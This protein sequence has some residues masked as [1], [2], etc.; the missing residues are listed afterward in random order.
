[1]YA[2]LLRLGGLLAFL[3]L[4]PAWAISLPSG[5]EAGDLIFREGT[6]AVS[7]MVMAV[8]RDQYSHVGMLIGEPGN[9]Q[10]IH[11]TPSEVPG[12]ADAVVVDSLAFF[13]APKRSR[14]HAVYHVEATSQQR[15][16]AVE[17]AR[18][19]LGVPFRI[20]E[21]EGT[22]CTL[23][24]WQAWKTAGVDLEVMFDYLYIPML[25]GEYLLPGALRASPKLRLL[26]SAS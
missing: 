20:G 2:W 14:R 21:P 8:G 16:K 24:V 25:A 9:W 7:A 10:V 6:E 13:S 12:R 26:P 23:L 19:A 11:A 3:W 22:Y 5:A 4:A 17:Q 15:V 1:M 18:L